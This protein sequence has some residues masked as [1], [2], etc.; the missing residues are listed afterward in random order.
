MEG[1]E[2]SEGF[3]GFGKSGAKHDQRVAGGG[4]FERFERDSFA[5]GFEDAYRFG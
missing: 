5:N 3:L 4:M 2:E 1:A